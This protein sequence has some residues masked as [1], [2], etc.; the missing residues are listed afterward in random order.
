MW[1]IRGLYSITQIHEHT[2]KLCPVTQTF[3]F[4]LFI[5]NYYYLSWFFVC[6]CVYTF[7][8]FLGILLIFVTISW[9][10]SPVSHTL[11]GI[12]ELDKVPLGSDYVHISLREVWGWRDDTV[13]RMLSLHVANLSL[14]FTPGPLSSARSTYLAQSWG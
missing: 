14:A 4:V 8:T 1:Q 9:L 7:Q 13:G 3:V 10:D 2:T 6:I 11:V 5:C 12:N